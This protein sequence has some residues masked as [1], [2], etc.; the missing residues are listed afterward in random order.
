MRYPDQVLGPRL[1]L[2]AEHSRRDGF[3]CVIAESSAGELLGLGYGYRGEPGQW[4][5]A[6]VHRGLGENAARWLADYFELTELH[7]QPQ[8]QGA[9]TGQ[10]VLSELLTGRTEA[11]VLLSTPEGTNRAW[12][13]Y[14]R[15]GFVDVLRDY[16][17][18]GDPRPFAVLGRPLPLSAVAAG[19]G[20]A[21]R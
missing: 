2:W 13:L 15:L 5:Y 9:G 3:A 10:A 19:A 14:R 21:C 12:R 4:W 20:A 6:E 17:F 11:L 8:S 16:R 7:V 1:A 18:T